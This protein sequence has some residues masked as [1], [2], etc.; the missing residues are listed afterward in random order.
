MAQLTVQYSYGLIFISVMI[1]MVSAYAA[2]SLAERI[3]SAPTPA[4][5]D[6][7]LLGG[8]SAM[9]TGIWSMHY[10]GMLAARLPMKEYYFLPTVLFSLLMA[11][12]ASTVALLVV[13]GRGLQWK[14]LLVGGV[15]MGGGIGA[16]HY[17]G[18]AAMRMG[19]DRHY[20]AWIVVLSMVTAVTFSWLALWVGFTVASRHMGERMRILGAMVMGLG[21]ASMHYIAMAGVSYTPASMPVIGVWTLRGSAL[22]ATGVA[23]M[24]LLILVA[25]LGT[26]ALDKKSNQELRLS[27]KLLLETQERLSET[28][29]MLSEL[30][31]R[32]G[33]TGLYNR[34]HFDA[35]FEVE[36]RRAI[37]AKGPLVLMM[38]D[39]DAFKAVN[40]IY[41]HQ[42]GD[43]ILCAVARVL[44]DGV[45]R[46]HDVV[47]RFGGEEFAVLLPGSN[48]EGG[49]G[50]A[51]N[52]RLG[53][54]DLQ[55]EHTGSA[56]GMLT[57]S[58]GVCMRS[59][60]LGERPELMIRDADVALYSAKRMGR[61]RVVM[62]EPV[63]AELVM[64][65]V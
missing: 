21:I 47:A 23:V 54:M 14:R 18:M 59:P 22:G 5:R 32:D 19:A 55:L 41:G 60:E 45:R 65:E 52:F 35:V 39:V 58:I 1:S 6:L 10:L 26:A 3:D 62:A 2:F 29:A 8:S 25:A 56:T 15:L 44:E 43:D 9:G 33:L 37:R 24:T 49:C 11:I 48:A 46:K 27:Q 53:V 51:E 17:T 40:D 61:N 30:S 16:M 36:W 57:V 20:T 31:T 38:I 42:R 7:W 13:S 12:C 64:E 34:R 28:V 50:I 63:A 4:Q